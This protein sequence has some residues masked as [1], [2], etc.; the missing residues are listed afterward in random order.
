MTQIHNSRVTRRAVLA[1]TAAAIAAP[2][3]SFAQGTNVMRFIP[4]IDLSTIDPHGSLAYV[5]R[6]HSQMVF[7]TLYGLDSNFKPQPQMVEGH[8]VENDGRL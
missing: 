5:T 3:L 2:R 8:V 7:D 4:Q 6:G 1:T